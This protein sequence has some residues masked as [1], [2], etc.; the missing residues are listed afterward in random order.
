M[1][2]DFVLPELGEN[3]INV[4]VTAVLVHEGDTIA[5]DD[6]IIEIETEKSSFDVPS[7]VAGIVKEIR[8]KAGG[9]ATVGQVVLVVEESAQSA[10]TTA[11]APKK[12]GPIDREDAASL[13]PEPS[14]SGTKAAEE[15]PAQVAE[16]AK[17]EVKETKPNRN[18]TSQAPRHLTPAAPSTRRLAREI[19]V[20]I[21]QVP[22]SGS[23][24]RIS[25]DDVKAYAKNLL[26]GTRSDSVAIA[27]AA[28][29]ALSLPDFSKFGSVRREPF[30]NVRKATAS[31]MQLNWSTIPMVTQFDKADITDLENLRK[32]MNTA[33][34]PKVTI[35][36]IL[37]KVLAS[38]LKKFPQFNA[39]LDMATGEV[40]YKEYFN[41]GVAVDTERGLLVPVVRDAARK[42]IAALA[43]D[44]NEIA[45]KARQKKIR[46]EDM[47]GACMT[48]TNL[49]GIGGYAFTPIVNFPEVAILG[50]SKASMEPVYIEDTFYARLMMPL[51]VTYDHRLIDG[52]D[53]ARFLRWICRALENPAILAFEG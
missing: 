11:A 32:E 3:I 38:A 2:K 22:G 34:G 37:L 39:S 40:V 51:C 43:G 26:S 16:P 46:P 52:A 23:D 9:Q 24:G 36:A 47:A 50:V 18:G 21:D 31:Q 44:L 5:V 28:L 20:D 7:T 4:D 45:D 6:S 53:A 35:T 41:I 10:S 48:I 19:G 27:P 15:A 8:V 33:G 30:S 1:T 13:T 12:E 25:L 17:Q 14:K 29:L 49:G 42:N